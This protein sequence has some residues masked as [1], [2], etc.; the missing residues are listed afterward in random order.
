MSFPPLNGKK[1]LDVEKQLQYCLFAYPSLKL[2]FNE[3]QKCYNHSLV[4]LT[5]SSIYLASQNNLISGA[6]L[7]GRSI[8]SIKLSDTPKKFW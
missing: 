6:Y 8:T 4:K 7:L 1:A 5:Y 2:K 3:S